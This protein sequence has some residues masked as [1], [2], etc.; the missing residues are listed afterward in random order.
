MSP[1]HMS[2]HAK[3]RSIS[4]FVL[5]GSGFML[6]KLRLLRCLHRSIR[7]LEVLNPGSDFGIFRSPHS[8]KPIRRNHLT[9]Q[10]HSRDLP[11]FHVKMRAVVRPWETCARI[12]RYSGRSH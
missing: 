2:V 12:L 5:N 3:F 8:L 6:G 10:A 1:T 4:R 11:Y 9:R 7:V